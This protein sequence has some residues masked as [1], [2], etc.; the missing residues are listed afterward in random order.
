MQAG[1]IANP[2][3][4]I[5]VPF[6]LAFLDGLDAGLFLPL[7]RLKY[8]QIGSLKYTICQETGLWFP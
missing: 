8:K 1:E 3:I 4:E 5:R 7:V 2:E 6:E